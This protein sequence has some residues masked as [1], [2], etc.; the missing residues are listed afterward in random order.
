MEYAKDIAIKF[1]KQTYFDIEDL[2]SFAYE[3]LINVVR[4][5]DVNC[6][7]D[8]YNYANKGILNSIISGIR[9]KYELPNILTTLFIKAQREVQNI[10]SRKYIPGDNEMLKDIL[11][12][13]ENKY[14][15]DERDIDKIYKIEMIQGA[16]YNTDI[17][18]DNVYENSNSLL[19]EMIS[20]TIKR[21]LDKKIR[22]LSP[23]RQLFIRMRYGFYDKVY[24][25]P[26]ISRELNLSKSTVKQTLYRGIKDLKNLNMDELFELYS[27]LDYSNE[28]GIANDDSYQKVIK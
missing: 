11:Y 3:G 26:E 21:K 2:E 4:N 10:Y 14:N 8:F 19:N 5:Y 6:G 24:S 23:Q 1:S 13:L 16:Y 18:I 22:R 7:V 25:R 27:E 9:P 17:E 28:Y 20:S 12:L 15:V